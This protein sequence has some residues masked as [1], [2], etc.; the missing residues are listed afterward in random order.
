MMPGTLRLTAAT[1][2]WLLPLA[3]GAQTAE[4]KAPA[5]ETA[6]EPPR[7]VVQLFQAPPPVTVTFTTPTLPARD[8]DPV[9]F[10]PQEIESL[11]VERVER[12]VES[13]ENLTSTTVRARRVSLFGSIC[14][15][16]ETNQVLKIDRL[17]PEIS[18]TSI[19]SAM[20]EFDI[21]LRAAVAASTR[22]SSSFGPQPSSGPDNR[23]EQRSGARSQV[24]DASLGGRLQT[25]TDY[26][27]G[28]SINKSGT[29]RTEGFFTTEANLN[30]TQNLLRG[31][32]AEVNLVR[33]WTAENNFII[34]LFQLQ[35]TL[36]DHVSNIQNAY[37]D[38]YLAFRQLEIQLAS[39][40]IAREQR[41]LTEELA[42]VGRVPQLDSFAAQAEEASRISAVINAEA[43]LK[44][45][46]IAF[47]RLLNPENF[48]TMW[49]TFVVPADEPVLPTESVA[50]PERIRL[51][52]MYRPDL[53]QAHFDLGNR[54]LEVFRTSNGLLPA[55][56][57]ILQ[58]GL[59]GVGDTLGEARHDLRSTDYANWR[60]GLQ[61]SM[62]LQNRAARASH[63]RAMFDQAQAEEAITNFEQIIEV[64]VRNAVIDIE[65]TSKLIES[66]R[67]TRLLREEELKAERE[68]Y[69][70]ERSTQI[71]VNQAQRDLTSAR[72]DEIAAI[73]ANIKA[74]ITLYRVEGTALQRLG[75]EPVAALIETGGR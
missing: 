44:R 67:I 73:V 52:R 43:E 4:P 68:K 64:D 42:R 11:P 14:R 27:I 47:L 71:S 10:A 36:I 49:E 53:R 38:L 45:R 25:G 50:L 66:T 35:S 19:E 32:G 46:Q 57:F 28:A 3:A 13:L 75:I 17:R 65:R 23:V 9:A 70:L 15:S 54:E 37:W 51:A 62:P 56:D 61:L 29:D 18:A 69:R 8:V 31:A 20:S 59:T 1:I 22:E 21:T 5:A 74:Y 6:P 7:T 24:F 40:A 48:S 63:R 34:S 16:L 39:Y 55:L 72:L 30:I 12:Y 41:E 26:S 2:A 58:A 60:L 33:V